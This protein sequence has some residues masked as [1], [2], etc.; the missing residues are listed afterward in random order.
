MF[1]YPKANT[2]G[3]SASA[4]SLGKAFEALQKEGFSILGLSPD[5]KKAQT[6]F[7]CKYDLPYPLLCDEEKTV[8]KAYE[9]WGKKKFMGRETVGVIRTTWLIDEEGT[10]THVFDKV[11]TKAHAQQILD[12]LHPDADDGEEQVQEEVPEKKTKGKKK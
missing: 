10:I 8:L 12:A 3:C 2:P 1:A 9:A 7:K 5:S 11:N 6:S 4:D